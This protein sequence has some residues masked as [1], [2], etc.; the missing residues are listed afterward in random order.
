MS[1]AA[2]TCGWR[3]L[4]STATRFVRHARSRRNGRRYRRTAR[5]NCR[6]ARRS[7]CACSVRRA[8]DYS[9]HRLYHYTGTDPEHFQNFVIFTNY[10]FYIDA[11]AE[12]AVSIW[13]RRIGSERVRRAGQC[14]HAQRP[15]SARPRPIGAVAGAHA[16]DARLHLVRP[17]CPRH[18]H[19]QYRHRAVEC[20]AISP[21]MS[22]CCV[23]MLG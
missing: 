22:R 23:R 13:P 14:R 6:P 8:I 21:T 10:Q 3:E 9:L 17:D 11:F 5:C 2:P 18:H 7:H 12:S 1:S 20:H 19:G 16:S 4:R 15:A